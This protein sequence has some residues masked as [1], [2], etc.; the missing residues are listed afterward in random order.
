M[1]AYSLYYQY[2]R[3]LQYLDYLLTLEARCQLSKLP[4]VIELKAADAAAK[5]GVQ[6]ETSAEGE[7][8]AKRP[9]FDGADEVV[10][11][12]ALI[13]EPTRVKS[14]PKDSY[15][16]SWSKAD[17]RAPG[18]GKSKQGPFD[19][20]VRAEW[21]QVY[22]ESGEDLDVRDGSGISWWGT[23][24]IDDGML[25]PGDAALLAEIPDNDTLDT[26]AVD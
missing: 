5:R 8:P 13:R 19:F 4:R 10:P 9:R 14:L 6:A 1:T 16:A 20:M 22:R 2:V 12:S 18:G 3:F 21:L 15:Q 25:L 17:A 26:P 24:E 7:R 11:L 23:Y